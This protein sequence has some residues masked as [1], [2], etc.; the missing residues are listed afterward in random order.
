MLHRPVLSRKIDGVEQHML[1]TKF[2]PSEPT[3]KL[4]KCHL[5]CDAI[6]DY[7]V[8]KENIVFTC[9]SCKSRCTARH[10]VPDRS[11]MLGWRGLIKTPYPQA[12]YATQWY[13]PDI[14]PATTSRV[15]PA[16]AAEKLITIAK[17]KG[18]KPT[19]IPVSV[20]PI[21]VPLKS[22]PQME[23]VQARPPPLALRLAIGPPPSISQFPSLSPTIDQPPTQMASPSIPR[24]GI[25]S[26]A[27]LLEAP[28]KMVRSQSLPGSTPDPAPGPLL[29]K[30]R[31][32]RSNQ[33]SL[34]LRLPHPG[35][36]ADPPQV[37][38]AKRSGGSDEA[39]ASTNKAK[40]PKL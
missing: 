6:I 34:R 37:T 38:L 7:N 24:P 39:S 33:S 23:P 22:S 5:R 20:R 25:R 30:I 40:K 13:L 15:S 35:Q 26:R 16:G 18:P 10:V 14:P 19:T 17:N 1:Y 9:T 32:V 27:D 21:R 8:R 31:P 4:I 2:T 29:I 11:S 3:G 12:I 28:P 36:D